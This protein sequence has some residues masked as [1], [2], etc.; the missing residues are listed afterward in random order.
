M[1][2]H[3]DDWISL[4]HM[5]DVGTILVPNTSGMWFFKLWRW[6]K[7]NGVWGKQWQQTSFFVWK[8]SF[9]FRVFIYILTFFCFECWVVQFSPGAEYMAKSTE[10]KK[11]KYKKDVAWLQHHPADRK[12][13]SFLS[14]SVHT[15]FYLYNNSA[16]I[17]IH[18]YNNHIYSTHIRERATSTWGVFTW[19][20]FMVK[21]SQLM[22]SYCTWLG[23]QGQVH[24]LW[25]VSLF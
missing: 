13:G 25:S 4:C 14:D 7:W 21:L 10:N 3:C 18:L 2:F 20:Y 24:Q 23:I 5:M 9:D 19:L 8:L 6:F 12:A 17:H 1:L 22:M 15:I 16:T 11:S